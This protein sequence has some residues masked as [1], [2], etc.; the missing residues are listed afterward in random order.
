M[1]LSTKQISRRKGFQRPQSWEKI[2]ISPHSKAC[3]LILSLDRWRSCFYFC[4][5]FL[6]LAC[7]QRLVIC[8]SSSYNS[9]LFAKITTL[10][11]PYVYDKKRKGRLK[12]KDQS[13]RSLLFAIPSLTV[14]E[15]NRIWNP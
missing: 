6:Q 9:S 3:Y 1:N 11:M 10:L 7:Y 4:R 5:C 8:S 12:E 15:S 13:L 14:F 2:A